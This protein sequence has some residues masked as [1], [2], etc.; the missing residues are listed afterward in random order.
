MRLYLLVGKSDALR[1]FGKADGVIAFGRY[2]VKAESR[3]RSLIDYAK[4]QS[5]AI[6]NLQIAKEVFLIPSP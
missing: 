3:Y 4:C 2:N 6:R 5:D 1:N